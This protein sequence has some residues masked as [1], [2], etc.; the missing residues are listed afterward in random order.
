MAALFIFV[1]HVLGKFGL[2][3]ASDIGVFLG[4][5]VPFFFALSGFILAYKYRPQRDLVGV[6]RMLGYRIA[7]IWPLHLACLALFWLVAGNPSSPLQA[8]DLL[9]RNVLMIHSW[10]GAY[11]SAFSFNAV[12]WS[13]SVELAF[14]VLFPFLLLCGNRALVGIAAIAATAG[15]AWATLRWNAGTSLSNPEVSGRAIVL[16]HPLTALPIFISGM[17]TARLHRWIDRIDMSRTAAAVLELGAIGLFVGYMFFN[18]EAASV[19]A[20][21]LDANPA[22]ARWLHIGLGIVAFVPR[23][24]VF[25]FDAGP[26]SALLSTRPLVYLGEISFAFYLCHP[27]VLNGLQRVFLLG[28]VEGLISA[29]ALTLLLSAALYR[30]IERPGQTVLRAVV[31]RICGAS[32][33]RNATQ[34]T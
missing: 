12:S 19:A 6:G 7:R 27:I 13:L 30:L 31:D 28:P 4:V 18:R 33:G 16:T 10:F 15:L 26:I 9:W 5:G 23:I 25:A 32:A 24:L 22:V 34:E 20:Q 29:L 2:P 1:Y 17:L 11:R 8:P 14:Y 3:K 21:L